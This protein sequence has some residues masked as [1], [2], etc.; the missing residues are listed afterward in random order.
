MADK[1]TNYKCPACT[2]PLHFV[3]A[4]GKLEC[5][6]CGSSYSVEEIEALYQEKDKQAAQ[7]AAKAEQKAATQS[8]EGEWTQ[9]E[10]ADWA[11][12]GMKSYTCPSCGAELICDETTAATSCPYCGNTTIVPGQLSGMQKPDYIIPFKLSKEDAIAAL[13]NHYKKK[14]LLPKIFSAQNHIEEIQGVYVPFWLFNGSADADIRY[15]CTRS[16]THREGDYDVTDT[17][18]FMVRRAGTVKFE[19]IPVDASSKMPDENMDS[20]E[21]FDYKELKA[22]SNAYLPGFLADKYDV[23]VDDCAPRADARCKSSCESALRSSVTGYSTC[24]P[25]EENIHIRRGKVQYAMLPV[26][27]LHTKWNGR[28]YLFS[29]NGQTGKLTGDLPVLGVFCR[30]CGRTGGSSVCAAVC[31]V[32]EKRDEKTTSLS[33]CSAGAA[34]R[35]VRE[36]LG[37]RFCAC[38]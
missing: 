15:N 26:W 10:G 31:I 7:A 11:E 37:L 2:G 12:P 20:I 22:F 3:G 19:K 21:P 9:P 18:H 30:N 14:P 1:I 16:M 35:P 27:M 5:D 29:M 38:V 34:A 25:E 23:S 32:R 33:D 36:R 4:S 6:Y 8:D 24:V 13:K 17:Q 28:D